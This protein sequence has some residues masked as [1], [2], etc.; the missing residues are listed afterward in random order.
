[1]NGAIDA[2]ATMP[3]PGFAL[4]AELLST[5]GAVAMT[6]AAIVAKNG[7]SPKYPPR[8]VRPP[9]R[10]VAALFAAGCDCKKTPLL[11]EGH[12]ARVGGKL[13]SFASGGVAGLRRAFDVVPF[14]SEQAMARR[15]IAGRSRAL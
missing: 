4:S 13:C 7:P 11:R 2:A 3:G 9:R 5:N 12:A 15:S 10:P 14:G 6:T 1:T 8:D